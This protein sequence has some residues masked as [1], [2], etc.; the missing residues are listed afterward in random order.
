MNRKIFLVIV[1]LFCVFSLFAQEKITVIDEKNNVIYDSVT[2]S[3]F[4]TK[5][6]DSKTFSSKLSDSA[7]KRLISYQAYAKLNP[8]ILIDGVE[9][10]SDEVLERL[11]PGVI[12]SFS[13]LK[14][15]SAL[16]IFGAR[17]ANGVVSITT[18]FGNK[19]LI[20]PEINFDN[21]E[22]ENPFEPYLVGSQLEYKDVPEDSDVETDYTEVI[23]TENQEDP[24][25]DLKIYP[26]PFSGTLH[27]EGAE[28]C[29]LQ[30][31]TEDGVIVHTQKLINPVETILLENFRSGVYFFC[32]K[33]GKQMKTIKGVK[34]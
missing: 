4:G 22:T 12:E 28:G 33:N 32:V 15:A 27:L 13:I 23:G 6:S 24:F 25:P 31:T 18:K 10:S 29:T 3:P 5:D 19:N 26:N 7:V 9:S 20:E 8:L 16:A 14:D 1:P 30:V 2:I 17:G 11:K 21:A 34:N